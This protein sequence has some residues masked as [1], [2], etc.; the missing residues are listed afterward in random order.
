MTSV[1]YATLNVIPSFT[2]FGRTMSTETNTAMA[3]AGRSGG[4]LFSSNFARVVGGAGLLGAAFGIASFVKDSV[5]LEAEFSRT[6]AQIKVATK[7]PADELARLDALAISLGKDTIFSANDA[8]GAMLELAKNGIKPATIEAGA[9]SSALTLAAAGGVD[10]ETAATTMG[11]ALNAFG[12]KGKDSASVAN[13]LAGAANASSASIGSLAQGLQ[14]ASTTAADTGFSIQETTGILAAFEFAGIKGSDAGTSLKT[15]LSRLIPTTRKAGNAMHKYGLDFVKAN[16]EFKG[17]TEIAEN[18]KQGLGDLSASERS[19]ALNTI[20]GSDA[21]RAATILTKQGAD[22]LAKFIKATSDQTQADKLAKANME[23]TAGAI[24]RLKGAWETAKLEFGKSIAPVVADFLTDLAGKVDEVGPKLT[25]FGTWFTDEGVPKLKRFKNFVANDVVPVLET[26]GGIAKTAAGHASTLVE[27]FNAMPAWA[28]KALIG[29]GL[30]TVAAN[31]VLPGGAGGIAKAVGSK[32]LPMRTFETNPAALG[33]LGGG[34]GKIGTAAKLATVGGLTLGTAAAVTAAGIAVGTA[35]AYK[36]FKPEADKAGNVGTGVLPAPRG[37]G[38]HPVNTD[39]SITASRNYVEQIRQLGTAA[40]FSQPKL[41]LL[42]DGVNKYRTQIDKTPR[43]VEL[44]FKSKGYA[45]R[46]AEIQRI[47]DAISAGMTATTDL[48]P[49]GFGAG[50]DFAGSTINVHAN[51][52][53][54]IAREARKA[55][56]RRGH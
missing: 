48:T 47:K 31:K 20:F 27:Q 41:A 22:G 3:A 43:Q 37:I 53:D 4:K 52:T 39:P 23:G 24:E 12:L 6:M 29:G 51:T 30:A 10:M 8:S 17:A 7:A 2:N 45:A 34:G 11:N 50:G 21:R 35:L 55:K 38:G 33:G 26:L 1:G 15:M 25:Q 9:L 5:K 44:L 19:A 14:Q 42:R 56:R 46:M 28:K 54:E 49:R 36:I 16:G 13:A 18:L 32:L 40:D